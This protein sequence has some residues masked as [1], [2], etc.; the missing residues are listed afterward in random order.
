MTEEPST[1]GSS[2]ELD[3]L[4]VDLVAEHNALDDV[5]AHISDEQW[6]QA[7]PSP[8]WN[9]ADQIGHLTYFDASAATAIL[10]PDA[11]G[12]SV[13]ELVAGVSEGN[14]DE[15]TLG[16]FRRLAPGEQL[17]SWRQGRVD[18]ANAATTLR[19]ETRVPW[20]GPSMSAKSF[21]SA[22]L[23]EVWAHGADVVDALGA[24]RPATPRLRHVAQLG[25]ITRAWSYRVRGEV[26]P[27]GDVRLE[28]ESPT[29]ELWTWGPLDAQ[30]TIRGPA[31][32]FCLV[33]TQRRHVKDT[34]LET[35][36]LGYHWLV[37]AQAFAGAASTGP[38]ARSVE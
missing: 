19:D 24:L 25:F 22:R 3:A 13:R 37:R 16:A 27:S 31:E 21:L 26:P 18:L 33:V 32:D 7:T 5:V 11:F 4:R 6:R 9:V 38:Q 10:D 34:A 17:T 36:E 30:D 15:F 35:G 12:L 8:G 2:S 28:L 1:P 20:Y 29:G 23:M 14:V